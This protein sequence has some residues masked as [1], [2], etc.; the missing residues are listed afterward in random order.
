MLLAI[1]LKIKIFARTLIAHVVLFANTR[2]WLL[3]IGLGIINK[4]PFLKQIIKRIVLGGINLPKNS[5]RVP[6]ALAHLGPHARHIYAD[7]QLKSKRNQK[8]R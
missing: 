8:V 1:S 7:L 3:K 6:I 5:E 4:F 2:P